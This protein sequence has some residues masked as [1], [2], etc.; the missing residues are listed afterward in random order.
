MGLIP[1][2]RQEVSPKHVRQSREYL[3]RSL[4]DLK[5]F[6]TLKHEML[7]FFYSCIFVRLQWLILLKGMYFTEWCLG[8]V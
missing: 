4:C 7:L 1:H 6:T 3:I 2:H 8:I 5:Y